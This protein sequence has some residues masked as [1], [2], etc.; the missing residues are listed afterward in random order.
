MALHRPTL[1]TSV[2]EWQTYQVAHHC[3]LLLVIRSSFR[4]ESQ[5]LATINFRWPVAP[6][7]TLFIHCQRYLLN[8]VPV[9]LFPCICHQWSS[10]YCGSSDVY[11]VMKDDREKAG[12]GEFGK[13]CVCYSCRIQKKYTWLL[14]SFDSQFFS[15]VGRLSPYALHFCRHRPTSGPSQPSGS[16]RTRKQGLRYETI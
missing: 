8:H 6:L 13:I 7:G 2:Q 14:F 10:T 3:V 4:L 15:A 12:I 9:F 16:P 11:K 5:S 1:L